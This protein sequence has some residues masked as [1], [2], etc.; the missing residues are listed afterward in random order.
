MAELACSEAKDPCVTQL[1][2][3]A[4][5]AFFLGIGMAGEP[6][7]PLHALFAAAILLLLAAVLG[8]FSTPF[9]AFLVGLGG[10]LL[11]CYIQHGEIYPGT[12]IVGIGLGGLA[13]SSLGRRT[14]PVAIATIGTVVGAGLYFL[15]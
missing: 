8:W 3:V 13:A 6:F 10:V 15:L 9:T 7:V 4:I 5:A 11:T 12:G 14:A 1:V 2:A